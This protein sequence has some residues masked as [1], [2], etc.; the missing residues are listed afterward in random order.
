MA[1][2]HLPP[3]YVPNGHPSS[4]PM[5]PGTRSQ[6]QFPSQ[7]SHTSPIYKRMGLSRLAQSPP[8]EFIEPIG[9][10]PQFHFTRPQPR[11]PSSRPSSASGRACATTPQDSEAESESEEESTH[12]SE[13][14]TRCVEEADFVLEELDS[15]PGY[16]SDIE[17]VRPDHY[18]D[19]KSD[20]SGTGLE[21]TEF[22]DKFKDLQCSEDSGDDDEEERQ[23]I[24]RK[25]K[26]R[27][28]AGIF[29]RTYSQSIEGDSSYSDDDPVDD[30]DP[31]A[32]R[33]RRRVRGPGDRSSLIFEDRGYPNVNHIVEVEEP[34]DGEVPH[35]EGPPSIPSDDGFTLDE[36]PF[37]DGVDASMDVESDSDSS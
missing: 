34:D 9:Q 18:E 23:R 16:D 31:T 12:E 6:A 24:Y 2:H 13:H 30:N 22:I 17:V 26:K 37:W 7:A 5:T 19:A 27:W 35:S 28:S 21:A 33:L 3:P 1:T 4:P 20:Y 36:L 32:R 29:K 8:L 25:K 11:E 15:D 10:G 14:P